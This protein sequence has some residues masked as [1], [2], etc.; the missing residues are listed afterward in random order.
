MLHAVGVSKLLQARGTAPFS[1]WFE[2]ALLRSV[3][4]IIVSIKKEKEKEKKYIFLFLG[5]GGVPSFFFFFFFFHPY[6]HYR[7][8]YLKEILTNT[9]QRSLITSSPAR[10]AF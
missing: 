1:N 10:T 9:Y 6:Y 3:R 5:G 7:P 8:D 4:P 2:K